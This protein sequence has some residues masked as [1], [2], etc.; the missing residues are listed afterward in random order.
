MASD[1]KTQKKQSVQDTPDVPDTVVEESAPD[2]EV[3]PETPAETAPV[4]PSPI[5]YA[6]LNSSVGTIL[7][8]FVPK[9]F[10]LDLKDVVV[11]ALNEQC[12]F[13]SVVMYDLETD[14]IDDLVKEVLEN[15]RPLVLLS[16]QGFFVAPPATDAPTE[17]ASLPPVQEDQEEDADEEEEEEEEEVEDEP[18]EEVA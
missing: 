6:K 17:N 14:K 2:A 4:T 5:V 13:V 18:E 7:C 1:K 8:V 15:K 9:M 12:G 3:A 16:V 10:Q 11:S